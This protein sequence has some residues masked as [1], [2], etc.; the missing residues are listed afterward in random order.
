MEM[1]R[2]DKIERVKIV[3]KTHLLSNDTVIYP[4][5]TLGGKWLIIFDPTGL[6]E[7]KKIIGTAG[8]EFLAYRMAR[9]YPE[10]ISCV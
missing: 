10:V 4:P 7:D 3:P 1:V 9:R 5:L 2:L 6:E 8:S